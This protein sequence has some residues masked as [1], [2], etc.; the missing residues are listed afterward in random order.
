MPAAIMFDLPIGITA[1]L[2]GT[3][4]NHR[5]LGM[6]SFCAVFAVSITLLTNAAMFIFKKLF[7]GTIRDSF[8]DSF[9]IS[10][11]SLIIFLYATIFGIVTGILGAIIFESFSL[12]LAGRLG[13][14]MISPAKDSSEDVK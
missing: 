7:I 8:F 6:K 1:L 12:I 2:L 11:D 10:A 3:V 5:R 9:G 14:K 13:M 4:A